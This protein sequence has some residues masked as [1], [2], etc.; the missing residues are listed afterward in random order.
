MPWFFSLISN[1]NLNNNIESFSY[2]T[3]IVLPIRWFS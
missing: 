2:C 1:L 3:V